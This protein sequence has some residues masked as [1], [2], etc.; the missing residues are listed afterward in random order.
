M[1]NKPTEIAQPGQGLG[2]ALQNWI[3]T[4][5]TLIFV[6][7]YGAALLGWIRPLADERTVTRLEPIIFVIIGYYFGR[8]PAQQN[9]Q[10][11]KSEL[12]RQSQKSDAAQHAKE[13]ARQ[14][15]EALEE[16]LKNARAALTP[17][18]AAEVVP[19]SFGADGAAQS[20]APGDESLRRATAIA[21]NIL[22]S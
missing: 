4:A 2:A 15:I 16:K 22:N 14:A 13:Q 5:L 3:M 10:A 7:L 12:G 20:E 11:L 9:E 6:L 1:S 17:P 19:M 18:A 8:L 21:L